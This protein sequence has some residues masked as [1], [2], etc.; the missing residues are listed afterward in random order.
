M[1]KVKIFGSLLLV[2]LF[3]GCASVSLAPPQADQQAKQFIA[4]KDKS[5]IY[6]YRNE[7]LGAAVSMPVALN[8][9][10][11]GKTGAHSYLKLST[12]PGSNVVT[13]EAENSSQ[14]TLNTEAGHNY[15]VWQEVKMGIVSA[16]SKL[17]LVSEEE[18]KKGVLESKLITSQRSSK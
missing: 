3:S 8:G 10:I 17:Q 2:T 13:S 4:D 12:E 11:V 5:N 9:Q 15:F 14:I 7:S 16:R 1:N 18:G 6:V